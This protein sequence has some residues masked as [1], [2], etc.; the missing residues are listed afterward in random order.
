LTVLTHEMGHLLGLEHSAASGDV[1]NATLNSGVRLMPT[2]GDLP[3]ST[4][5][6][7]SPS[8]GDD[9]G[10]A[11]PSLRALA[12]SSHALEATDT[13][14]AALAQRTQGI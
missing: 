13:L 6:G 5:A 2:A 7:F 4:L 10:K 1:M 9:A 3:G 14:F 11:H 8:H 12:V